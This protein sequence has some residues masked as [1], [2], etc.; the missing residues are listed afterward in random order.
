MF[1]LYTLERMQILKYPFKYKFARQDSQFLQMPHF[2]AFYIV[3]SL[4]VISLGLRY[5]LKFP[6]PWRFYEMIFFE[7][8]RREYFF[9]GLEVFYLFVS[10]TQ[11]KWQPTPVLLPGESHGERNLVGYSPWGRK[12]LDTTERL[13]F[14]LAFYFLLWILM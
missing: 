14:T 6:F 11:I 2:K 3:H 5:H 13:H 12:E 10:F 1:S 8:L 7:C 4:S 9:K